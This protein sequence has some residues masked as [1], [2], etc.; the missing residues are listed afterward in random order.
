MECEHCRVCGETIPPNRA[1]CP[2]CQAPRQ[3]SLATWLV[4]GM[5]GLTIFAL[6]LVFW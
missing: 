1:F 5:T 4:T 6:L 3:A 2:S